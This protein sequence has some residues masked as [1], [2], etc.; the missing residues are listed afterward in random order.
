MTRPLVQPDINADIESQIKKHSKKEVKHQ[1]KTPSDPLVEERY[2]SKIK[3]DY[4]PHKKRLAEIPK[5]GVSVQ[6]EYPH[7]LSLLDCGAHCTRNG[8][9]YQVVCGGMEKPPKK[10]KTHRPSPSLTVT[11][12]FP[13][14][15]TISPGETPY[16]E[17]GPFSHYIQ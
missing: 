10:T 6:M 8:K 14:S 1:K 2:P 13:G 12:N 3:K 9:L 16:P 15:V 7:D 11:P 17:E 5:T 4:D